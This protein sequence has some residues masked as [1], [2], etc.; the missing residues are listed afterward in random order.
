MGI[1]G[2]HM[3]KQTLSIKEVA[4]EMGVKPAAVR[5]LVDQGHLRR[6]RGFKHKW[7]I[8]RVELNRYLE[9]GVV[10]G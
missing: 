10:M 6:L 2:S 8:S 5:R 1:I 9:K 7:K 4:E 3:K